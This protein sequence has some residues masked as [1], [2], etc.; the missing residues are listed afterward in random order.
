[1][2]ELIFLAWSGTLKDVFAQWEQMGFFTYLLPF[3]LIFALIFGILTKIKLFKENKAVNAIIALVVGLMALQFE[4]VSKFFAEIFPRLGVG[5]AI[6]LIILIL[7]GMFMEPNKGTMA[8][9][10][11]IGMV[12]VVVIVMKTAG[13]FGWTW[14]FWRE[15]M[16]LIVGIIIIVVILA[17]I[18]GASNRPRTP[19]SKSPLARALLGQE[20]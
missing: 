4:F 18:I 10:F 14:N 12:I 2:I 15:N 1:M 7:V 20:Q 3:L 13:T 11:G 5:L 17:V 6:I 19:E 16:P 8:V 9:M